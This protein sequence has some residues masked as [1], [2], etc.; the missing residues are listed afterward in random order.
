MKRLTYTLDKTIGLL[1]RLLVRGF[2]Y[3]VPRDKNLIA[4]G[5]WYGKY[6]IGP[7]KVFALYLLENSNLN[8][9]WIGYEDVLKDLP[10]HERLKFVKKDSW[11]AMLVLLR[12]KTWICCISIEWD[13]TFL[14]LAGTAT[15]INTW[16][17]FGLKKLGIQTPKFIKSGQKMSLAGKVVK[18]LDSQPRPWTLCPCDSDRDRLASGEPF[19]FS[20]NKFLPYGTPNNDYMILNKTNIALQAKLRERYSALFGFDPKSKIVLYFPTWRMTSNPLF[21]FYNLP[22]DRQMA[23]RKML[24][25]RGAILIE[26]HHY[27]TFE[28]HPVINPSQCSIVVKPEHQSLIDVQELLL[29]AD[30]LISDY[31]GA[32]IDFGLLHR[33]C[34]HFAYDYE[35]YC[36]GDSGFYYSLADV[37]AGPIVREESELFAKVDE[38][39]KSPKFEPAAKYK[40]IVEYE[41]GH[42]CEQL[43]R[44]IKTGLVHRNDYAA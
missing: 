1:G 28:L 13:L 44:F 24:A 3:L 5:G 33:P 31:S 19:Y 7:T 14:P 34:V 39:L 23:W 36:G 38:Y 30:M 16:H 26:K 29:I 35:E 4:I 10:K 18:I 22:S 27:R 25:E 15:L 12:A 11:R 20:R 37:A 41:T 42:S 40:D 9:V 6:F 17:S 43:L 21:A 2:A 8:I 32:Y